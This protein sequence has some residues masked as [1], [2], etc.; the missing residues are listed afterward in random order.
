MARVEIL[1]PA[2][3]NQIAAGE[4]VERP[5]SIVKE[6][7]ENALDA[8][9]ARITVEIDGGGIERLSVTDD[10]SGMTPGDALLAL[11][12][13]ATSKIRTLDDLVNVASLGF[14]GE[15]LPSIASVSRLTLTTAPDLSGL[16][17]EVRAEKGQPP[18][19]RPVRWKKGT[20]VVVEELFENVPARRKFL[21][22][23]EAEMKACVR[24][25]NTLSLSRPGVHFTLFGKGR[26]L[27]DFPAAGSA[28][29]R[30]SELLGPQAVK[31][32]VPVGFEFSGMRL[33]G[34]VSSA[35][36]SFASRTYQWL[37][38]NGRAVKDQTIAH[39]VLLAAQEVL[40][41]GR[42]PAFVL[43]I[44]AD[45]ASCDV[46][47]HPQKQEVRFRD[48]G[49][50]HSLVH[51]GLAAALGAGK[52]AVPVSGSSLMTLRRVAP[53]TPE[54]RPVPVVFDNLS[55]LAAPPSE[56]G[57]ATGPPARLFSPE[58]VVAAASDYHDAA[59][60]RSPVGSLRLI[61]QYR[62]SF[63][64]ADS[65]EGLVLID[66]HVAHERVRYER[67]LKRLEGE[68]VESQGMLLPVQFDATA[69]EALELVRSEALL[70]RAGFRVSELS[71]RTFVV[72]AA[73]ADCPAGKIVSF[74]R[75]VL[76]KLSEMGEETGEAAA[77]SRRE[78]LA[79]SLACRGAITIN[80][81]LRPEEAHRLL[82]DLAAC[83]DPWTCP[84]GRPIILTFTHTEL[85]KRFKRRN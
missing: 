15:A 52:G 8:G 46:N 39:A 62:D 60:S 42:H 26:E 71:G 53:F 23:S 67:I 25:F 59:P 78:A 41:D 21:K 34:A 73:P 55:V 61:G 48:S 5:A 68:P 64:L 10:G 2:L 7:V 11:E 16:G 57:A 20:R 18:L 36:D 77:R 13:H 33:S 83:Q 69:E 44:Q 27:L 56:T 38:V 29:E 72:T 75:E 63:L 47:V 9:A 49:A 17:T 54:T 65:D 82:S 31:H 50:V 3:I 66:Q 74:L 28:T 51:R 32:F 84:H 6:L 85:E 4:V 35:E 30:L 40:R 24:I 76:A 12:R 37:F 14:R 1:P 58:P 19:S 22:S 80:T 45:P 79:A 81:K 43:F 70:S